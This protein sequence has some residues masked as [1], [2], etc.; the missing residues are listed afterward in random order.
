[1]KYLL[2]ALMAVGLVFGQETG[3]PQHAKVIRLH[4][5]SP[6]TILHLMSP[7][8]AKTVT[9][10]TP[11]GGNANVITLTGPPDA[12]A[13]IENLI[14]EVDA[15][16]KTVEIT[17]Y[18]LLGDNQATDKL[19]SD[20]EPVVKQLRATFPYSNYKVWE[21]IVAR[22][23][24]GHESNTRG[25]LPNYANAYYQLLFHRAEVDT[26]QRPATIT[27][28]SLQFGARIPVGKDEKGG[29][30]HEFAGVVSA[31]VI[32]REGQKVVIG[33]TSVGPIG[34]PLFLVLS[35]KVAE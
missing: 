31:D 24:T 5:T 11:P 1:M 32:L 14:K 21:S 17:A 30:T 19:P 6:Q 7:I 26:N 34:Q 9:I 33:K 10:G 23:T 35:A 27:L 4:N 18:M 8:A 12:V 16:A 29:V 2:L 22:A 15:P 25:L 13:V 20:L 3:R 28:R